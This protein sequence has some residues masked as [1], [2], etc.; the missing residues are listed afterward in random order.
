MNLL[1]F[2][3]NNSIEIDLDFDEYFYQNEYPDLSGYWYPW[4]KNNGFS[5]KQRL[6]HHYYLY[7]K[8]EGRFPNLESKDKKHVNKNFLHDKQFKENISIVCAVKDR[9]NSL[10]L[11]LKSWLMFSQINNFII[12]DYSSKE[13]LEPLLA[14]LSNK[15]NV[16]RIENETF[17]NISKAFNIGFNKAPEGFIL[18][19]DADYMLNPYLNFFELYCPDEKEFI[20]GSSKDYNLDN[21]KGFFAYLNGFIFS[22]KKDLLSVGGYDERFENYGFEDC[23]LYKRLESKGLTRKYLN[24]EL[25]SIFH[26]PHDDYHR[27]KNYSNKDLSDSWEKNRS[28][29]EI[30]KIVD[31]GFYSNF[32]CCKPKAK[33]EF[34]YKLSQFTNYVT[35]T[36]LG[37]NG[38]L[39]NQMFQIAAIIGYAKK[40]GKLPNIRKWFC[41]ESKIEFSEY[42]ENPLPFHMYDDYID[43]VDYKEPKFSYSEIPNYEKSVDLQG[44]F[45][46]EK[47]FDF[48]ESEVRRFFKPK[49]ALLDYLNALHQNVLNKQTCAIHC[50]RTDYL[51]S[52]HEICDF[53]YFQSAI[54]HMKSKNINNFFVFSDDIEWCKSNFIGKEFSFS[55]NHIQIEDLFLM[56]LCDH[57][58]ISNSSFSWWASWLCNNSKKIIIAPKT[59]FKPEYI[60]DF[61]NIYTKEMIK[62]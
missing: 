15:I 29:S 5:E 23:D 25:V 24:H 17:F 12:V 39:G 13:P 18:K 47:Y 31:K 3:Q 41:T 32:Y 58:I 37:T 6:F 44:Y 52:P 10:L 51:G 55:E 21:G 22:R 61:Q 1:E 57:F 34:N 49:K 16:I 45:Q 53:N 7:G 36:E 48:C 28:M 26:I 54:S 8:K 40:T 19:M 50:R 42:F 9:K 33:N 4:S 35:S 11:C 30:N 56:N 46:S 14:E 60:E 62:I 38:R 43:Y 59:W 27:T 2:Y 20:T